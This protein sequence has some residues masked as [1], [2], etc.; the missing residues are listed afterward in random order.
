MN[1][2]IGEGLLPGE[3]EERL[4]RGFVPS[5]SAVAHGARKQLAVKIRARCY[6]VDVALRNGT[7]T[8]LRE[9]ADRINVTERN[10]RQH[11][12]HK[13]D[14]FAFPPT[15]MA[16]AIALMTVEA[17]SWSN[18]REATGQLLSDLDANLQGRLLLLRL[19]ELHQREKHLGSSDNHFAH[20]LRHQ[21]SCIPVPFQA[22]LTDWVGFFTDG[23]RSS[24]VEWSRTPVEPLASIVDRLFALL[25]PLIL[26]RQSEEWIAHTTT[27]ETGTETD[28]KLQHS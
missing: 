16:T 28:Q 24:L 23:L 19:V 18:A 4:L 14:L 27:G 1:S 26:V 9:I 13:E 10:L 6:A 25:D 3:I 5:G 22:R 8:P 11:F 17:K 2:V 20:E 21:L 15:E 12:R 7:G